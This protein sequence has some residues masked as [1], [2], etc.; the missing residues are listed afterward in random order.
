[1][2]KLKETYESLV[3]SKQAEKRLIEE[4]AAAL[5]SRVKQAEDRLELIRKRLGSLKVTVESSVDSVKS[6]N[7][8]ADVALE[9]IKEVSNDYAHNQ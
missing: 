3:A 2:L 1:V 4:R 7:A 5:E 9:N 8:K 6:T